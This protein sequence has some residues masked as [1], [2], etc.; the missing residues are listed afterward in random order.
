M[1]CICKCIIWSIRHSVTFV[2]GGEPS[3]HVAQH[4][5]ELLLSHELVGVVQSIVPVSDVPE[6]F[7]VEPPSDWRDRED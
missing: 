5:V 4:L 6:H 3:A 7:V 1:V 2:D